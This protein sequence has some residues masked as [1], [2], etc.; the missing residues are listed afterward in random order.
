[1]R[2]V[3]FIDTSVL[4]NLVPVPGRDQ[5]RSA[6]QEELKR[7]LERNDSFVLPI[8]AVIET[9]NFIAQ[10]NDGGVRR[11]TARTMEKLLRLVCE[12][13]APWV[14]HDVAWNR[15]FLEQ[16]LNGA[17]TCID[18]MAHAQARLGAGDLCILVE[19]QRYQSRTKIK[20][21]IWT[22]DKGLGAHNYS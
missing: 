8:T 11:S 6:V 5:H 4:C 18:Y 16:F 14:L 22:L 9:G 12:E 2:N 10:L 7:R 19:R 3:V 15:E 17:D 1:M 20:A 13:K 21:E